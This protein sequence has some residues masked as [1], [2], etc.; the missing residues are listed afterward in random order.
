MPSTP[1]PGGQGSD[2]GILPMNETS[3]ILA[4][5]NDTETAQTAVS[6]GVCESPLCRKGFK[7]GG[8]VNAK[9]FCSDACRMDAWAI[10]RIRNKLEHVS[11][12]E[13]L[14]CLREQ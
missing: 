4:V 1:C 3:S 13:L 12:E 5:V 10:R 11:D 2:W 7:P 8:K 9:R 6:L 14:R